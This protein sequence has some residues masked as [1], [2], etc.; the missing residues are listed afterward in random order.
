VL[1]ALAGGTMLLADRPAEAG[2][3][4]SMTGKTLY[5]CLAT[6]LDNIASDVVRARG[7]PE[8]QQA[9]QTAASNL[10]TATSKVQALSAITQ[11]RT[12][13]SGVFQNAKEAGGQTGGYGA[14]ISAL[15]GMAKLVQSK[16]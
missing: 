4:H 16:G 6:S 5:N 8:A 15:S 14:I 11:C 2:A 3:C 12:V 1:A 9:L 13:L 7:A 10:R